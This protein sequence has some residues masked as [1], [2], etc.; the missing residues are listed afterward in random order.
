MIKKE[1]ADF[2]GIA[3]RLQIISDELD[4]LKRAKGGTVTE[5]LLFRR[6]WLSAWIKP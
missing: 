3:C 4:G 1:P 5:K 2:Q 6:R